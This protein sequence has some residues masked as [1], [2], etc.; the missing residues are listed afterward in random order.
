M[1]YLGGGDLFGQSR[2][3]YYWGVAYMFTDLDDDD[4]DIENKHINGEGG[5]R[6]TSPKNLSILF[7]YRYKEYSG[8]GSGGLNIG[9]PVINLAYTWN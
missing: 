3:G 9:G 8:E 2:W 5:L 1:V 7:G 6:W 4:A